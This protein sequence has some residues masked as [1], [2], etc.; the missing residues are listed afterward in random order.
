MSLTACINQL[1][2]EGQ[3]RKPVS[4]S[5][6][7]PYLIR[8]FAQGELGEFQAAEDDFTAAEQ[9]LRLRPDQ[10]ARYALLVSRGALR[11]RRG[12]LAEAL[13]DLTEAVRSSP[14]PSWTRSWPTSPGAAG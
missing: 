4:S 2:P 14:R 10:G 12:T 9:A 1:R 3:T 8:G 13:Q 6:P 7:W 11:I 5:L